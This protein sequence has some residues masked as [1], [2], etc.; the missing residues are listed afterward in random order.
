MEDWVVK[1]KGNIS[2]KRYKAEIEPLVDNGNE[3]CFIESKSDYSI[4]YIK[5]KLCFE[6]LKEEIRKADLKGLKQKPVYIFHQGDEL[7]RIEKYLSYLI[8][9][10]R[11]LGCQFFVAGIPA[12]YMQDN[13]INSYEI[14]VSLYEKDAEFSG[15]SYYEAC[16]FCRL[17]CICPGALEKYADHVYPVFSDK[18]DAIAKIKELMNIKS[19]V[20]VE[21][22]DSYDCDKIE[23]FFREALTR[24]GVLNKINEN[25]RVLLK[26]NLAEPFSPDKAAT[27]H[28]SIIDALARVLKDKTKAGNIILAEVSAGTNYTNSENVYK[29]TGMEA[30]CLQ[31]GI[32]MVKSEEMSFV[33]KEANNHFWLDGTDYFTVFDDVDL[34][35]NLPKFKTHGIS[36]FTGAI[37]NMFGTIHP[38]ERK[39]IHRREDKEEFCKGVVDCFLGISHKV[40]VNIMDAIVGMEGDE[41]PSYGQP[42]KIGALVLST[43]PVACD[44]TACRTVGYN[45]EAMP[46]IKFAEEK[47]I[48]R[49]K[50]EHLAVDKDLT[51]IMVKDFK[52]NSLFDFI[53]KHKKEQGFGKIF[54]YDVK[55]TDRCVKCGACYQSCPVKAI[56]IEEDGSFHVNRN[57]CIR[58]Y[59]CHECC[60]NNAIELIKREKIE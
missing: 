27:T 55:I 1:I 58:C 5:D 18:R 21:E 30:V 24:S 60:P 43:D 45:P 31:H 6:S 59:T 36:F 10:L 29:N 57:N 23:R 34:V 17:R 51:R 41:G 44:A 39:Y 9:F 22:I 48:G 33:Y 28:P 2:P 20:F 49:Y 56:D 16:R 15:Y 3:N 11:K 53:N 35:I 38:E 13:L 50:Q 42:K 46:T 47:N 7:F 12:C 8:I 54:L 52:K 25:T 14:A 19:D 26:P 32:K 37:K 4:I 40:C